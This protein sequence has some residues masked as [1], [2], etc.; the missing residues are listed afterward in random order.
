MAKFNEE[1]EVITVRVPKSKKLEAKKEVNELIKKYQGNFKKQ[2]EHDLQVQCV[3]WFRYQYYN[4]ASMLFAIPNG[5]KRNVIVAKKLK[6]EGVL[7]GV[8]DLFLSVPLKGFHGLYIELKVRPNKLTDSQVDFLKQAEFNG[9]KTAICYTF[10]EFQENI[11]KY[12]A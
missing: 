4:H 11:L 9:Y 6:D 1:T 10:E 5:G 3:N 7:A 2:S 12:F 8:S